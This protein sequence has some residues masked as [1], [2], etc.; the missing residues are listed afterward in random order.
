M[1]DDRDDNDDEVGYGKPPKKHRF[2]KGVSGNPRG[3]R[4]KKLVPLTPDS[5]RKDVLRVMELPMTVKTPTG[6]KTLTIRQ[7]TIYKLAMQALNSNRV[8]YM[9]LW[10]DLAKRT[11]QENIEAHPGILN[12]EIFANLVGDPDLDKDGAITESLKALIRKSKGE[13]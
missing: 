1:S 8:T 13:E 2:K 6:E 4:R 5:L 12:Y 11:V 10:L 7:A 9:R 3:R